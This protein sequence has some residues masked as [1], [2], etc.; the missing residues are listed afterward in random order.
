MV[1]EKIIQ[2]YD[3]MTLFFILKARKNNSY[4]LNEADGNLI[5]EATLF[6]YNSFVSKYFEEIFIFEEIWYY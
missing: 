4:F 3:L 1:D 5:I 2:S 6:F